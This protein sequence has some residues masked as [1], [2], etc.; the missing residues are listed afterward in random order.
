MKRTQSSFAS[1][2]LEVDAPRSG[3]ARKGQVMPRYVDHLLIGGGL[4]SVTAAE[5]LRD[6]GA[7]GSILI[8]SDEDVLP[9]NKPPLSKQMLRGSL[10]RDKLFL[11]D[12]RECREK[13]IE[14]LLGS[15][16]VAH[17]SA[18]A[19]RRYGPCSRNPIWPG[20]DRHGRVRRAHSSRRA[21]T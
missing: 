2:G 5:A 3:G 10:A 4:A 15:S 20:T 18:Q 14:V 7:T 16:A 9:Y 12:E 6:A 8:L 21:R 17:R 1:I 13:G 19:C 11:L